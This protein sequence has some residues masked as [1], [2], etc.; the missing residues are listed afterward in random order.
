MPGI[1]GYDHPDEETACG[2]DTTD[3]DP[4]GL[5]VIVITVPRQHRHYGCYHYYDHDEDEGLHQPH[6]VRVVDGVAEPEVMERALGFLSRRWNE[7]QPLYWNDCLHA[8]EPDGAQEESAGTG[9]AS[10]AFALPL[11]V[12]V[13]PVVDGLDQQAGEDEHVDDTHDQ[14]PGS[15]DNF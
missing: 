1:S 4:A 13:S 14:S 12:F 6:V 7:D 3:E 15:A 8:D 9:D 11:A 10:V 2:A 5:I